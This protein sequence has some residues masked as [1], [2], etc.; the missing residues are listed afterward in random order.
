MKKKICVLFI[1]DYSNS[2][3]YQKEL[4]EALKQ[5]GVQ[6]KFDNVRGRFPVSNAFKRYCN[7][8]L[9]HIHW[10]HPFILSIKKYKSFIRAS[11]FIADLLWQKLIFGKRIVWTVHNIVHHENKYPQIE[12]FF[13]SILARICDRIII[14]YESAREE[15]VKSYRLNKDQRTK[16]I[17]IPHGHYINCYLNEID[18]GRARSKLGIDRESI[19]FLYFGLIRPYKGVFELI[20]AFQK[21]KISQARL[22]IVGKPFDEMIQKEI[23]DHCQR[24]HRIQTTL[25]FIPDDDVQIYM[26]AAD[27]IVLPFRDIL[28]SGSMML[29]MSFGKVV[30]T[31]ESGYT[32]EILNGAGGILYNSFLKN[33]LYDALEKALCSDLP[34]M[35]RLNFKRAQKFD[36]SK[37]GKLTYNVYNQCLKQ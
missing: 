4:A 36:W 18:R 7:A 6:V 28:T 23:Q 29:A 15:V 20:E 21:L 10:Q 22:L 14:H 19:L 9:L 30:I 5:Y 27:V 16:L 33:G 25:R 35:G 17:V 37:T 26:N 34:K 8:G 12:L 3:P 11:I 1:P 32:V 2:N 13:S 31:P 24:D